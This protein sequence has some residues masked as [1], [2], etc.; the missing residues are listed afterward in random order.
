MRYYRPAR[1]YHMDVLVIWVAVALLHA[2]VAILFTVAMCIDNPRT[3]FGWHPILMTWALLVFMT[4]G[5]LQ[6]CRIV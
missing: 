6:V 4:N 5:V 3:A 2:S 1:D